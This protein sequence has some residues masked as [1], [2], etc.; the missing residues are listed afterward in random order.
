LINSGINIDYEIHPN[1]WKMDDIGNLRD[2]KK[3][4]IF[5]NEKKIKDYNFTSQEEI[6]KHKI[7]NKIEKYETN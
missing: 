7:R 3:I 6:E 5:L 1:F 2:V 4:V